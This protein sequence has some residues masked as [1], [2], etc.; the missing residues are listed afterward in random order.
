[1]AHEARPESQRTWWMLRR[2]QCSTRLSWR[3][4]LSRTLDNR[5]VQQPLAHHP[6]LDA[7][8]LHRCS[9]LAPIRMRARPG[10]CA[11]MTT[12]DE[13]KE[14]TSD[15][16]L[17]NDRGFS[18]QGK[19]GKQRGRT[20]KGPPKV[21]EARRMGARADEPKESAPSSGEKPA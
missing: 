1:M 10:T 12:N 14:E 17:D 4:P 8:A 15:D 6:N 11:Q 3:R 9:T 19:P 13:K 5:Q 20:P 18:F 7:G 2:I 16:L 21:I